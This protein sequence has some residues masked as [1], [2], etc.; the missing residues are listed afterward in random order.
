MFRKIPW[1][2]A[3]GLAWALAAAPCSAGPAPGT[4]ELR[5]AI[6]L[7][8]HGVRSPLGTDEQ[9]APLAAA[10][11]PKWEVAPG[12]QTPRGNELEALLGAY[13]RERFIAEGIL[14]GRKEL[15]SSRVFVRTDNDQRTIETGRILG[16]A[17]VPGW[18]PPIR[19]KAAGEADPLFSPSNAHVGHPDPD[20]AVASVLGRLGG[21]PAVIERA[22]AEQFAILKGVLYGRPDAPAPS[23]SP[24][25][26][27]SKVVPGKGFELVQISGPLRAA[28]TS[29]ES[30]I[31][32]YEDGKPEADV[33]W[34][35]LTPQALME[36]MTLHDLYFDL[37]QRT[38]YPAQVEASNLASHL[39]DTLDQAATGRPIPG[40]IGPASARLVVVVGHDT[41][42]ATLGGL[43]RLDWWLPG[44][45]MNPTLPGGALV[46]ELWRRAG[47]GKFF[48]RTSYVA[49]TPKQMR[50]VQPVSL[51]HPP[52][53]AAIFVPG[54][55]GPGPD[56][57]AALPA[58]EQAVRHVVDSGFVVPGEP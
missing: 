42:I 29:S 57:E 12:I 20:T 5:L 34:G 44:T 45:H 15:D 33:G 30:L 41:N 3:A 2:L 39:T 1:F 47:T 35:R 11:W 17:L 21:D 19:S 8:R 37:T 53:R 46:F 6:V 23:G 31:L 50:E 14:T 48:V 40:A 7:T 43:L 9:M 49:Q 4:D 27:L 52:A 28:V 24:F 25:D 18:E 56:F 13:Y 22:Y 10:P 58:F 55:G 36:V 16:R 38:F 26:A 51:A 54:C 32:E